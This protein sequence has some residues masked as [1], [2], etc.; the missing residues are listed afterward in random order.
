MRWDE[1]RGKRMVK[2]IVRQGAHVHGVRWWSCET[3]CGRA[4]PRD[5]DAIG[6]WK[7]GAVSCPNCLRTLEARAETNRKALA[8]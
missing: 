5:A 8:R 1:Y 3:W 4:I 6:P 2:A 7:R